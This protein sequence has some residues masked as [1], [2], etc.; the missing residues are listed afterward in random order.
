MSDMQPAI[1]AGRRFSAIWI[2]PIVALLIGI[3][4]IIN[5]KLSEG[6]TIT[7]SFD[8]AESLEA[9]K[10]K[11]QLLNVQVGLVERIDLA[12]DMKG[13][14]VTVQLKPEVKDLLR[15]D[16]QFW[17]VRARVGAGAITGLG[18]IL[19][20]AYIELSPGTGKKGKRSYQGL[21]KPLLT[22][23]GAAGVRLGLYS[24]QAGS[25]SSG[26]AV[27]YNGYKV[28]RIEDMS[29]DH[30]R[31]L[32]RYDVFVD[33]PYDQL[34]TD[35]VRF[36]DVSGISMRASAE[37]VE[38][39]TGSMDT[40]LLG[41]VSFTVPDGLPAGDPV[42]NGTEFKLY[43]SHAEM[44]KR[45]FRYHLDVVMAFDQSL[46]GLVVGAPVEYRGIEIGNVKRIMSKRLLRRGSTERGAPIPVLVSIVPGRLELPDT[47]DALALMENNVVEGVQHG[48]R[49]SLETGN[50]VTGSLFINVDYYPDAEKATAGDFD[51]YLT[52]PTIT[53][54]LGAIEKK[55]NDFLDTLNAL[56]LETTVKSMDQTLASLTNT[57]NSLNA[58]LDDQDT[59]QL[60]AQLGSTL[61]ELR[62]V[63]ASFSPEGAAY[64]SLDSNI[65]TLNQ[66]L[67]NLE[68]LTD[69]LTDKPNALVLPTNFPADPTPEASPQ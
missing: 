27:L 69:T 39:D 14:I 36:W 22:P 26:D 60:S 3:S 61:L 42:D 20:G 12:D 38:I 6:P 19:S 9:G 44:Q 58:I 4:M 8:T 51:G 10:T 2:L 52:V 47:R 28:G 48:L 63:L 23:V 41:G 55:L 5:T 21:E 66:T 62:K 59:Q 33:A 65:N 45:P 24:E 54:G 16:T 35:T 32:V 29:F 57:L 64:Q 11:I 30:E 18:T 34:V 49:A 50:L 15:E 56:P 7:I 13:V 17:I 67:H 46:R 1:Q 68:E 43:S 37:G 31:L 40:V 53:G 25:V